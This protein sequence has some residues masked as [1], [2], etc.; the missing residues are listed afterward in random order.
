L[1]SVAGLAGAGGVVAGAYG[2]RG[3]DDADAQRDFPLERVLPAT[4]RAGRDDVGPHI[5]SA[6]ARLESSG[7]GSVLLPPGRHLW[8][9][10][11]YFGADTIDLTYELHGHGRGTILELGPGLRRGFAIHLNQ[12]RDVDRV[13]AFPRHP[14][15]RVVDLYVTASDPSLEASLCTYSQA[16]VDVQRVRFRSLKYGLTGSGYT[17]LMSLRQISWEQPAEG[18]RL[19]LQNGTGGDGLVIEQVTASLDAVIAELIGCNGA[20]IAACIG[21]RLLVTDSDAIEVVAHHYDSHGGDK[22][23]ATEPFVVVR[24]SRVNF[25]GGWDH[26]GSNCAAFE[27]DDA[28]PDRYSEVTWDGYSFAFRVDA[29]DKERA[30][31]IRVVSAQ[32]ATTL[33]FRGCSSRLLPGGDRRRW[34]VGPRLASDDRAVQAAMDARP[35]GPLEDAELV[36]NDGGWVFRTTAP[37]GSQSARP[38]DPRIED[39]SATDLFPGSLSAG[40]TYYYTLATYSSFVGDAVHSGRAAEA[41]ATPTTA[42]RAIALRVALDRSRGAIR[43]WRGRSPGGYDSYAELTVGASST[44]LVDT[45]DF[46]CGFAWRAVDV[47][48][49]RVSGTSG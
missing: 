39:C 40:T 5:Q 32:N 49:P 7:R 21:G 36:R 25:R 45:G 4:Y 31:D 20:Q 43:V 9:S 11:C 35:T 19:Y 1:L 16:S 12:T 15:L 46:V 27:I 2:S 14:R 13:V 8:N 23:M 33:R 37:D 28:E 6:M 41:S 24:N 17:D 30:P 3:T 26:V 10:P 18:G 48:P 22:P 34:A 38:A 29:P 47:P 42:D 44:M